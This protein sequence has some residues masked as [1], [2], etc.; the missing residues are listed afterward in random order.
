MEKYTNKTITEG[1][2]NMGMVCYYVVDR[3][4][5]PYSICG[6]SFLTKEDG[7]EQLKRAKHLYPN[8]N[9]TLE[10][11]FSIG[12]KEKTRKN[13]G[14]PLKESVNVSEIGTDEEFDAFMNWAMTEGSDMFS[15]A[16]NEYVNGGNENKLLSVSL[17]YAKEFGLNQEV[18]F[19]IAKEAAEGLYDFLGG[20]QVVG[21]N[22]TNESK[23]TKKKQV[24]RLTESDIHRI[25]K[26]SVNRMLNEIGNTSKGRDAINTAMQNSF[27]KDLKKKLRSKNIQGG[28]EKS[29]QRKRVNG[30]ME[31]GPY[32]KEWHEEHGKNWKL[33]ESSM[34]FKTVVWDVINEAL[35]KIFGDCTIGVGDGWDVTNPDNEDEYVH[36]TFGY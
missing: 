24:I 27:T 14:D 36:I 1:R 28:F 5:T 20:M 10:A 7:I 29:G 6:G 31:K 15:S 3:E 9:W 32:G 8:H 34:P 2:N 17:R 18:A 22:N 26:E 16:A 12:N 13:L 11:E 35:Y 25:V 21:T 4:S 19:S 23:N 30:Y 33:N